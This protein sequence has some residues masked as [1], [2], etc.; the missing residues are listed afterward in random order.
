[1]QSLLAAALLLT[2]LADLS[3]LAGRWSLRDGNHVAEE[4]WMAPEGDSILGTARELEDGKVN[5]YELLAIEQEESGPVL[6]LLH[7]GRK[8]A[9]REDKDDPV[10]L[11]LVSAK[12][13]EVV[14][15]SAGVVRLTYRRTGDQLHATVDL[16]KNGK[17]K[18]LEFAYERK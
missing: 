14:F 15:E 17:E 10:V 13:N 5:F 11:K 12:E 8:L 2:T 7:F 3:F 4:H 16:W 9:G 6:R 18:R 1:M